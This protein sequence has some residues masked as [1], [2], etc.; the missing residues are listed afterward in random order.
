[1]RTFL[2][3]L[4]A[5]LTV[6]FTNAQTADEIVAKNTDALGGKEKLSQVS[7]IHS[8]S[9]MEVMGNESSSKTT[10]LNGKGYKNETDFNGQQ[11]VQVVT[12]KG[13]WAIN[14]FG[15][16]ATATALPDD[17][18]KMSEDQVYVTGPL[19][20]YAAHG[21]KVELSG[22]EK[23]CDVNAYKLKYTNKDSAESTIYVDPT[24]WLVIQTVKKGE[25]MGQPIN[26]TTSYSDY[27]KTDAG[28][29]MPFAI[30]I[31][32]QQFALNVKVKNIEV[33]KAVD[34]TVFEMPK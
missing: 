28:I 1:M 34:P 30:N 9:S 15:G 26:V 7:S 18:F 23:V 3:T 4:T 5:L 31:D 22:Q 10:V 13:G 17:Q 20:D 21:G 11:I 29:T 8:E 25:A 27:R 14:P 19:F 2:V 12:D 6:T 33:N 16:S 24:T 32:M